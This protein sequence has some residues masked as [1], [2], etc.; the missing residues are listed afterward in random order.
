MESDGRYIKTDFEAA[1][2]S[3][4]LVELEQIDTVRSI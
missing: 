4:V 1:L 3:V 2:G